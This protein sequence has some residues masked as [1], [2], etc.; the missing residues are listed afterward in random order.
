MIQKKVDPRT[1]SVYSSSSKAKPMMLFTFTPKQDLNPILF[2]LLA[3]RPGKGVTII[4]KKKPTQFTEGIVS[5]REDKTP[6]RGKSYYELRYVDPA[7][8]LDVKRRISGLEIDEVKAVAKNL[9]IRAQIG[10]GHL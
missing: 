5:I 4:V 3:I 1:V 6:M 9:N 10:K 2:P 7:T 8:G